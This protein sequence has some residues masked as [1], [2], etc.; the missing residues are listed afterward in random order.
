MH[1]VTSKSQT[2]LTALQAFMERHIYPREEEYK[3]ALANIALGVEQQLM[4]Y[5]RQLQALQAFLVNRLGL[6]PTLVAAL[7]EE[8]N[9]EQFEAEDENEEDGWE[10]VAQQAPIGPLIEDH[11]AATVGRRNRQ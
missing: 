6:D 3:Q 10:N 11:R 8:P 4:G 5:P 7:N 1:T 2:L 9:A